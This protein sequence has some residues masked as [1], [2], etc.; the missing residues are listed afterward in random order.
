MKNDIS[1][2]IE[3]N[4]NICRPVCLSVSVYAS[5][6]VYLFSPP[7]LSHTQR[8]RYII[9]SLGPFPGYKIMPEP[10]QSSEGTRNKSSLSHRNDPTINVKVLKY[11]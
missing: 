7:A 3:K 2:I 8:E 9:L 6:C 4:V 10:T 1:I 11:G 5:L